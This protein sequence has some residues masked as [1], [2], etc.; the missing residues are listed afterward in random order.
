[1]SY[2][3]YYD[4]HSDHR[5]VGQALLELYNEDPDGTYKGVNFIVRGDEDYNEGFLSAPDEVFENFT[6]FIT[7]QKN[8]D[9]IMNAGN[10]YGVYSYNAPEIAADIAQTV[11]TKNC[12]IASAVMTC[13]KASALRLAVGIQ[14]VPGP[15]ATL[16]NRSQQNCLISFIHKPFDINLYGGIEHE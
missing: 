6:M 10:C 12:S 9:K 1:M 2:S 7:D 8:N 3:P 13:D 4:F 5:A 16:K 11:K 15:F 14:S